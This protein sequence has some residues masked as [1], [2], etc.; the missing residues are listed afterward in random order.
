M[1]VFLF[2]RN[3]KSMGSR[4]SFI[5]TTLT[6]MFIASDEVLAQGIKVAEENPA[7]QIIWHIKA[8]HP[9]GY[10]MDVK[11]IDSEGVRHDVKAF[12]NGDQKYIMEVKAFFGEQTN[13][14]KVLVSEKEHKPVVAIKE[15]GDTI[16]VVAI[17]REGKYMPVR[18]LRKSGYIVHIKAIGPKGEIYGV[19]AISKDGQ[20]YDVKGVKMY[21]KQLE[22]TMHGRQVHAHV[23]ALPQLK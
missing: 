18:G 22:A 17:S 20:L 10:T 7:Q 19:K 13:A 23:V 3:D 12:E 1:A 6:L 9:D 4:I 15:N 5:F 21:D 2:Y 16:P 8:L 14:V 11:A